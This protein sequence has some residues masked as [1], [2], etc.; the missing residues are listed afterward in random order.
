MTYHLARNNQQAGTCSEYEIRR[1]LASGELSPED[2]CW[3][4]GMNAWRPLGEVFAEAK[5]EVPAESFETP[6]L[7]T[8]APLATL[9]QRLTAALI[10]GVPMAVLFLLAQ[11][12]QPAEDSVTAPMVASFILMLA[13]AGYN[14]YLL[15]T[16]GQT[17][18]KK[19]QRIRIV[20]LE[21]DHHP[22]LFRV[23]WLRSFLNVLIGSIPLLDPIPIYSIIDILCIFGKDRRCIHD[24]LAGTR[25]VQGDPP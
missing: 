14:L 17:I 25:V 7:Q 24:Y 16:R 9:T 19:L 13:L 6:K 2:L 12:G 4:E 21:G 15:A 20:A 3:T 5:A 10:D 22:G 11:S 23:F 8:P 1:R 18:G